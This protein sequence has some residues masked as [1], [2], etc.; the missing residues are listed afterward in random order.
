MTGIECARNAEVHHFDGTVVTHENVGG[1]DIAVHHV[2]AVCICKSIGN[3]HGNG[4]CR[5]CGHSARAAQCFGKGAAIHKFHG[6]EIGV[7]G[8]APVVHAHN[9][10]VVQPGNRL[11]LT[12]ETLHEVGVNGVLGEQHLHCH[13]AVE[14]N[15]VRQEH[16]GHTPAPNALEKFVAIVH[17]RV[18]RIRHK[19]LTRLPA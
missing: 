19:A 13:V 7:A 3:G 1:L 9:V 18:I 10:G 16:I 17:D 12:A 2:V 4:G 5:L 6:H 11:C 14:K 15:V 8:L